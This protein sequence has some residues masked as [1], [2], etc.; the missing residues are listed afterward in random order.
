MKKEKKTHSALFHLVKRAP[1]PWYWNL[2]VRAA[3]VILALLVSAIVITLLTQ[4]NP[5]EVYSSMLDGAFGT[6]LRIWSL[7]QNIAILLCISLAV[8]PAFMMRF[9]NCGAEGQVLVGGLA[10]VAVMMFLGG[11]IPTPLLLVVMIAASVLAG[12]IW[13][14]LPAI[15][16]ALWN[17]NETLFTLMMN[18][19]A[20]QL[21][22]FFLKLFVKSGSGILTPMP[23]YGLPVIGGQAYLLNILIVAILTILV[24]IYLKYTKQGYE[25]AVVGESENTARYIGVNVKK[26]I[27]RTLLVSGALCGIAGLLLVGGTNH[28]IS[29]TTAGGRGFT[30]IMVSWLA[31]FN[32]IYMVFTTFLIVFLQKGAQ[33]ISTDFRLPSAISDIITGIILFFIIGCEFF[34]Q[35]KILVSKSGKE[36]K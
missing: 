32:P 22:A 13:A 1:L 15:C 25:I 4:K 33:Q 12:I 16:K 26:V 36:A 20:I 8:T 17:T 31:K 30:A 29:T 14:V 24:Y 27:I 6:E 11:K 23:E 35:Y 7:L 18:Y 3:A 19:V 9:W 21:V 5:I 2:A 28:T 10:T 34:L